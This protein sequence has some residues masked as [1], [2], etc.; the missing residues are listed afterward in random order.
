MYHLEATVELVHCAVYKNKLT[1]K[2]ALLYILP[3]PYRYE[4]CELY[5]CKTGKCILEKREL[6]L[7]DEGVACDVYDENGNKVELETLYETK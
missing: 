1:K 2:L 3:E 6:V 4:D 7:Q 5:Q